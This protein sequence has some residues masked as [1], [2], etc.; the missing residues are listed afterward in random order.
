M[1]HI[2]TA[3]ALLAVALTVA[4]FSIRRGSPAHRVL[5]CTWVIAMAGVALSSFWIFELRLIGPYSPIHLLSVF[6][7]VQLVF[8]VR[9]VRSGQVQQHRRMMRGMVFGALV[10]AGAFTLLPGR[11]MFQ[12]ISGG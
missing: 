8:A 6:V 9:A 11:T 7:L 1:I 12:V 3:L 4:I 10:V 5:G 2:H